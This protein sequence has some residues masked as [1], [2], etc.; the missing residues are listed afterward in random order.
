MRTNTTDTIQYKGK[1][2]PYR[3]VHV[4]DKKQDFDEDC[5][6]STESLSNELEKAFYKK[7]E[8]YQEA[9]RI[10][11]QIYGYVPDELIT[12]KDK[13]IARFIRKYLI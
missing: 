11:D 8:E 10:D 7:D 2:Y 6:V 12:K 9:T 13:S 4:R 5:C 3:V 1:E